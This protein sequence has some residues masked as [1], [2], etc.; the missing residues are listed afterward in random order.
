MSKIENFSNMETFHQKNRLVCK[1]FYGKFE[2]PIQKEITFE[3]YLNDNEE[4]EETLMDF[5]TAEG[6]VSFIS[7]PTGSGKTR[8]IIT[9]VFDT[10]REEHKASWFQENTAYINVIAVPTR[11]L[12][13]QIAQ[14]YS[15]YNIQSIVGN[16]D[17]VR[18]FST[19]TNG[20]Y[21]MVYDKASDLLAVMN[22]IQ[23]VKK[24]N[25]KVCLVIDE[26]HTI[27]SS[28]FRE[29]AIRDLMELQKKVLKNKGSVLY[30][31]ATPEAMC[32]IPFNNY[33][34]FEQK[35]VTSNF[36]HL[37][38][39]IDNQDR[40]F[41]ELVKDV[42]VPQNAGIVR[43][44][45]K[46][47]QSDLSNVL[48]NA[49]Y[50]VYTLNGDDKSF[51]IDEDGKTVYTNYLLDSIINH[52]NIPFCHFVLCTSMLD[53][54]QNILGIGNKL[55]KD[56][57]CCA[58]FCIP[59]ARD[60]D[61]LAAIQFSHRFR[62]PVNSYN[63]I[64]G[65]KE[66][67]NQNMNDQK[68]NVKNFDTIFNQLVYRVKCDYERQ[69][70]N[71]ANIREFYEQL[72]TFNEDEFEAEVKHMLAYKNPIFNSDNSYGGAFEY[73][74][75]EL[76]INYHYLF[77]Y[78]DKTYN[79]QFFYNLDALKEKL[80]VSFGLP[81]EVID[82]IPSAKFTIQLQ[83]EDIKKRLMEHVNDKEFLKD[84]DNPKYKAITDNDLFRDCRY[85][86]RTGM[87]L[88]NAITKVCT[89]SEAKLQLLKNE[90]AQKYAITKLTDNDFY[91]LKEIF[92]RKTR[93]KELKPSEQKDRIGTIL[94]NENYQK[95][96]KEMLKIGIPLK[97]AVKVKVTNI[98][99]YIKQHQIKKYNQLYLTDPNILD[100]P[101]G[102]TQLLILN[103]IVKNWNFDVNGKRNRV[104]LSN[105]RIDELL[106]YMN[107]EC[108]LPQ[109]LFQRECGFY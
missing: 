14:E 81:V 6:E 87:N 7:A 34:F 72:G 41:K 31:T 77:D 45:N 70:K 75:G 106:N 40:T 38:L 4:T 67:Y 39:H 100:C 10:I 22:T 26:G 105:D 55:E 9:N 46:K 96:L 92:T 69:K 50:L 36:E 47:S 28:R 13:E 44:N 56:S 85:L 58:Y 78:I 101:A 97:E 33:C 16:T 21:V 53:A 79:K 102:K 24:K 30:I 61:M 74:N 25:V 82:N 65:N 11:A 27:P 98:S 103:Y 19:N 109:T 86:V 68:E 37:Y 71:I 73:K 94:L 32:W 1:Q 84:Y 17:D 29:N 59:T 2:E 35:T 48:S 43:L 57:T 5:A 88:S 80:E 20:N 8:T 63:I 15:N 104:K 23:T 95:R 12:S 66:I 18:C 90:Q 49:G 51:E 62:Y 89:L 91:I 99:S 64:L 108:E 107:E 76:I 3:K 60:F 83:T 54:G 42:I 93:L 52:S